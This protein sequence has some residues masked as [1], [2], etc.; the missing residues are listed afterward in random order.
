[1]AR[2]AAYELDTLTERVICCIITVH[3]ALGPGF[4]ETIYRNALLRELGKRGLAVSIEHPVLV[5]YDGNPVGKHELDL[6]IEGELIV[7]LKAVEALNKNHYA[8][9]RSYLKATC[10]RRALLVNC[11]GP[12]ADFRRVEPRDTV[13]S[14]S[15]GDER[16]M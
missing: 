2:E 3:Q 9:V 11:A 7:E 5:F 10:L 4:G 15:D 14:I 12:R 8:Q 6:L 16:D 13:S 1:M